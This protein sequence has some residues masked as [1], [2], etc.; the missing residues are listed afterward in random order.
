MTG[1]GQTLHVMAKDARQHR[2][3]LLGFAAFT[4]LATLGAVRGEG[5]TMLGSILWM[6]AL[7]F[8]GMLIV[9]TLVQG[10]SPTSIKAFWASRPLDPRSVLAAKVLLALLVVVAIPFAGELVALVAAGTPAH[11][12]PFAMAEVAL[13]YG[14]WL[15]VAFLAAAMTRG[16][17]AF[18]LVLAG[19]PAL[20]LFSVLRGGTE[21]VDEVI[22]S[23]GGNVTVVE[24]TDISS[25]DLPHA[26][27]SWAFLVAAALGAVALLVYLYRTRDSRPRTWIAG[28]AVFACCV[29]G[30][31]PAMLRPQLVMSDVP[32]SVARTRF[33]V[34]RSQADRRMLAGNQRLDLPLVPDSVPRGQRLMLVR[35]VA[36]IADSAGLVFRRAADSPAMFGPRI[37]AHAMQDVTWLTRSSGENASI[38]F[39]LKNSDSVEKIVADGITKVSIEGRVLVQL[40]LRADTMDLTEHQT[41]A[42]DGAKTTIVKWRFGLG[43][44]TLDLRR[45]NVML[46]PVREASIEPSAWVDEYALLNERR[47]EALALEVRGGGTQTTWLVLPGIQSSSGNVNLQSA[48]RFPRD[49]DPPVDDEWFRNAKLVISHWAPVGGYAFRADSLLGDMRGGAVTKRE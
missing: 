48:S 9:A 37:E 2:W 15:L 36:T 21:V 19:I 3:L 11:A 16:I 25:V 12:L 13:W 7:V 22:S 35:A 14:K 40:A 34:S 24:S 31:D 20:G 47:H 43:Q 41:A 49:T 1:I 33:R 39:S 45:S 28:L 30:G 10:D 6:P 29:E 44:A 27:Q 32:A 26:L 4:A 23:D 8:G 17:G 38:G 42:R 18:L 5:P 46:D